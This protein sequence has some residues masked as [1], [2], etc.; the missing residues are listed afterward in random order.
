[1]GQD[2]KDDN[3]VFADPL[4][5]PINPMALT[6]AFR[7]L[8]RKEGIP[9]PRLH[10][11]RHMHVSAL[12]AIGQSPVLVQQR[13]GHASIKTTVDVYGHLF[14]GQQREAAERFAQA[15]RQ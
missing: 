3:L 11:L 6:R 9:V 1:M 5:R 8:A 15:M 12:F 2:Y 4:G 10:D 13:L 14:P 7:S